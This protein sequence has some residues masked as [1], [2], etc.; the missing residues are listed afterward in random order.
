MSSALQAAPQLQVPEYPEQGSP[1]QVPA[2]VVRQLSAASAL[3]GS[4]KARRTISILKT[5]SFQTILHDALAR[6][7]ADLG[8]DQSLPIQYLTMMKRIFTGELTSYTSDQNVAQQIWKGLPVTLSLTIGAAALLDDE[9]G[10]RE[11]RS[12]LA[13]RTHS[14]TSSSAAYS[15]RG[16]YRMQR[17]P[18]STSRSSRG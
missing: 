6:V 11:L 14:C 18:R 4:N 3:N 7:R 10:P 9:H 12:A 13:A 17:A 1:D 15:R 8:L 5:S 2:A 16:W